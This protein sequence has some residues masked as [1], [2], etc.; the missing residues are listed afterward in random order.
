MPLVALT[1]VAMAPVRPETCNWSYQLLRLARIAK[2]HE[3]H[4]IQGVTTMKN[5]ARR[6]SAAACV[7][8]VVPSLHAQTNESGRQLEEVVVTAQ[9]RSENVQDVPLA[10]SVVSES[11]ME[12]A[13]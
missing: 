10:V 4:S 6:A 3:V 5:F 12:S 13:G 1:M 8:A 9:K 7:L 2:G 11:Q